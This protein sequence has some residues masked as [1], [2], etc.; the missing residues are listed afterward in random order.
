MYIIGDANTSSRVPMWSSV[1]QL[2]EKNGNI[3][4]KLELHCSRH[5]NN[6]I[7]VS[8]PDDFAIYAPEGGCAEKCGLRLSCGHSCAVKCH[9]TTLHEA[10]K[11][12]E[13]C[14]RM[15][16][17]G[18]LCSRKCNALCGECPEKVLGVVLPC[19]HM[20]KEVE[21][22]HMGNL[23]GVKCEQLV[24]R[25]MP[26]CGHNITIR[27]HES[28]NDIRCLHPCDSLLPCGHS[29]RKPCWK[30][31]QINDHGSCK[32]PCGRSFTTCSHTCDQPCHSGTP[33]SRCSRPCEVRC[34]HSRCPKTCSDPCPPCAEQCGW[35]C[36][37]RRDRCSMPCAVPC[38]IIPCGH[39]CEKKLAACGHR[40]PGVCGELCPDSEFC[41][42]CCAPDIL[43]RN[44]DFIMFEKYG[45]I[46]IDENPLIFLSC[47][48]FY[49]V[50]SLDGI[51]ELNQHY[52]TDSRTGKIVRPKLSQR[53]VTSRSA[54]KGCPECRMPLRNIDRYNR[55]VK[56]ALLDEA[57]RRFVAQ[58]NSR[59]AELVEE[60][61]KRETKI[62]GERREFMLEWSQAV[63][64]S[65][66]LDQVESSLKAYQEEGIRLQTHISKFTKSVAKTEQ[67][68]GR[69]NSIFA[70]AVAR[71]RDITTNAFELD[72]SVIQTGFQFRGKCFSLRLSWAILWDF[73]TIYSNNTIDSRIR[74][75]LRDA[76]E[77]RIRGL[78]DRCLSLINSSR[79]AKFPQQEAEAQIYHA[80]FS[81]L[82]LS[83]SRAQGQSV[84]VDTE[85]STRLRA[86]K[87]LEECETL[88]SR[89]PGTLAYLKD[90]IEKAKRLVNGGTFYSFVTTE[91]KREVYRAM[92]RQFL[93]TGHWYYCRNNHPV[94]PRQLLTS[95]K[96]GPKVL[97]TIEI[98]VHG[99]RMW[100]ANGRSSMSAM[101]GADRRS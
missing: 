93:G 37:H 55:I 31:R 39:R 84:D 28:T 79:N 49:T 1:I 98:T 16:E 75:A 89:Y 65:R 91:E 56:K 86:R 60:I 101:R 24:T 53:V 32:I 38:D 99:G 77:T 61:Q 83:N 3:G 78:I 100:N 70:S 73:D 46:E 41:R 30:C 63:G 23:A 6:K 95:R 26:G 10:V 35:N 19:G 76:V 94:R 25:E 80:L 50:S 11:C 57:T 2:L 18:H 4:P 52:V 85:T 67:P 54:P 33:C 88:C 5:P 43:E 87:S 62:E 71:Q 81:M 64:E 7:Y 20:A 34:K 14:T 13:L 12:M 58:A 74:S 92:A 8:S 36:G 51:M 22:Q 96:L 29:C 66:D 44:V 40:C 68:F 21:C 47:G 17:C 42:E 48:H 90:D 15:R 45:Q 27:C 69:V 82:S 59:C 72:E 97:T 9:S